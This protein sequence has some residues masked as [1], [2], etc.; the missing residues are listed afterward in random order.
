M[1]ISRQEGVCIRVGGILLRYCR[2]GPCSGCGRRVARVA[3]MSGRRWRCRRVLL[4]QW[5]KL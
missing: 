2:H 1:Y 4:H 3:C 5:E